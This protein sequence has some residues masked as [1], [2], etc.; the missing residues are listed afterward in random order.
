MTNNIYAL[1]VGIDEYDSN[2]ISLPPLLKGCVNDISAMEQYLKARVTQEGYALHLKTLKNQ[3]A[4]RAAIIHEFQNHLRQAKKSDTVLFYFSGHGSQEQSPEEFVDLGL[5]RLNETLVCYDSRTAE[6]W[7]LADKELAKLIAELSKNQPHISII[8]DCCNSG[9]GTRDTLQETGVRLAGIDKRKR[10]LNSF[11]FQLEELNT[12]SVSGNS[13]AHPSGWKIPRGRHVLLSACQATQKAKEIDRHGQTRGAFSYYLLDTLHQAKGNLTYRDLLGRAKALVSSQVI[14]QSP[15]LELNSSNDENQLFL[16]GAIAEREPYFIVSHNEKYGWVIEGGAVHGIQLPSGEET[17]SLA[18]FPFDSHTEDLRHSSKS[19]GKA[20]VTKVLPSLSKI[21]ISGIEN[22]D[23]NQTFKAVITGLP[24]PPLG[25]YLEGDEEGVSLAR[26]AIQQMPPDNNPSVYVREEE[27]KDSK[28]I[29]YRLLCRDNQYVIARLQD[30]RPLVA[31][32]DGYTPENAQIAIKR[33][34]HIARWE[35]IAE[36]GS[37]GNGLIQESDIEMKLICEDNNLSESEQMRLEYQPREDGATRLSTI[38]IKLTNKSKRTLYCSLLILSDLFA[39]EVP[40]MEA[41]YV[42]LPPEGEPYLSR[43]GR[44]TLPDELG[45]QVTEYNHT[46]KLIVSTDEFDARLLTQKTLGASRKSDKEKGAERG[47]LNPSTLNRLM[48]K[49]QTREWEDAEPEKYED[50]LTKQV[51]ITTVRPLDKTPVSKTE[52]KDLGSGVKLQPHLSL[53]ANTRLSSVSQASRNLGDFI[54]PLILREDSQIT[55][56][57]QFTNSRGTDPGLSVLELTDVENPESVTKKNPLKLLVNISLEESENLLPIAY[58]GELYLPLGLGNRTEEGRTEINLERLPN[59]YTTDRSV[60]GSIWICFVKVVREKLG[61][62]SEDYYLKAVKVAENQTVT[63]VEDI[64]A[65][66]KKA[67]NILLYVHGILGDTKD[68]VKSIQRAKVTVDG[69]KLALNECYDLIL[70]FDY[71]NINTSIS[72]IARILKEELAKVGL[73]ANHGKSLQIVA[74][75]MGGLVSRWFIEREEGNQVVQ[76][77]VMLGTPNAGSPWPTVQDLATLALGIGLNSLSSVAWPVKILGCLVSA[78]EAVDVTLDQMK[79]NSDFLK[80]LAASPDPGIPY[81]VIAGNT[82]IIRAATEQKGEQTS[83][84]KRLIQKLGTQFLEFP[85][86]GQP[87]DIAVTVDSIT[88]ISKARKFPLNIQIVACDHLTYFIDNSVGLEA[89]SAALYLQEDNTKHKKKLLK[90]SNIV[91]LREEAK[92]NEVT[93]KLEQKENNNPSFPASSVSLS[94][95]KP[96]NKHLEKSVESSTEENKHKSQYD[97]EDSFAII[98]GIDK[99]KEQPLKNAASDA[100]KLAAILQEHYKYKVLLLLDEDATLPKLKRLF[101][102]FEKGIIPLNKDSLEEESKNDDK[103]FSKIND[104]H[105][106]LVY[107]AGHGVAKDTLDGV[108]EPQGYLIPQDATTSQA[109]NSY[110]SLSME[111]FHDALIKLACRHM[112]VILDCCFAASFSWAIFREWQPEV[113]LNRQSY[114]RFISDPA[115]QVITSSSQKQKALDSAFGDRGSEDGHSPFALA[116]FKV[117]EIAKQNDAKDENNTNIFDDGILTAHKLCEYLRNKVEVDSMERGQRQTPQIWPLKNHRAGEYIFLLPGFQREVLKL[118]PA[119]KPENNPYRGLESYEEEHSHLFFGRQQLTEKL[120][121]KV[122]N[123]PLTIVTGYSGIGKSSLVKA[124]LIPIYIKQF[125]EQLKIKILNEKPTEII[126]NL[127]KYH[128]KFDQLKIKVEEFSKAQKEVDKLQQEI[129]NIE[130]EV[131]NIEQEAHDVEQEKLEQEL[132]DL[133]KK[134][135]NKLAEFQK[136]LD[137]DLETVKKLGYIKLRITS[138]TLD[139]LNEELKKICI[140]AT[141]VQNNEIQENEPTLISRLLSTFLNWFGGKSEIS[142][143]NVNAEDSLNQNINNWKNLNSKIFGGKRILII[144]QFEEIINLTEEKRNNFLARLEKLVNEHKE[145]LRIVLTMSS[146]MKYV[147]QN[148]FIYEHWADYQFLVEEMKPEQLREAIEKPAQIQTMFF[149]YQPD[150]QDLVNQLLDD[151]GQTPRLLPLVSYTLKELYEKR[152][153]QFKK[154]KRNIYNPDERKFTLKDYQHLGGVKKS[155][156]NQ[157]NSVYEELIEYKELNSRYQDL[158]KELFLIFLICRQN[159][160]LY[161]VSLLQIYFF[162]LVVNSDSYSLMKYVFLELGCFKESEERIGIREEI[163]DLGEKEKIVP[164]QIYMYVIKTVYLPKLEEKINNLQIAWENS[165]TWDK[166][167]KNIMLRMVEVRPPSEITRRRVD[168]SK[169]NYSDNTEN[170]RVEKILKEFEKLNL[171]IKRS[172]QDEVTSTYVELANDIV[173]KEWEEL[174]ICIASEDEKLKNLRREIES[175]ADSWN[176]YKKSEDFLWH[177]NAFYLEQLKEIYKSE[178]NW[179]NELEKDFV[180]ASF[181]KQKELEDEKVELRNEIKKL[182]DEIINKDLNY[183]IPIETLQQEIKRLNKELEESNLFNKSEVIK[184]QEKFEKLE[185]ELEISSIS[186]TNK[187]T[188]YQ[189]EVKELEESNLSGINEVIK[190]Q[191]KIE[192]VEES[193]LPDAKEKLKEL[194]SK[195]KESNVSDTNEVTKYQDKLKELENELKKLEADKNRKKLNNLKNRYIIRSGIISSAITMTTFWGCSRISPNF[196]ETF[197]HILFL[198]PNKRQNITQNP[199]IP[200][201]NRANISE[202]KQIITS[203][204]PLAWVKL[205]GVQ[206]FKDGSFDKAVTNLEKYLN[207]RPNDPEALIY[208]NNAQ[209]SKLNKKFYTIAVSAPIGSDINGALEILR[210]VAQ[211][212]YEINHQK[213]G[214]NGVWLKVLIANDND[215][216]DTAKKI[217]EELVK[218]PDVLGVVGHFSSDVTLEAGKIYNA[219]RLVAISPIS[220]STKLTGFGNYIFRTAPNDSEVAKSLVGYMRS[221]LGKKNAAVFYN[222]KSASSESLKSE[223]ENFLRKERGQVSSVFDL[224]DPNFKADNSIEQSIKSG[225][226][227]LV[228]LP[229]TGKL[230][231]ALQIVKANNKRLPLLGGNDVYTP[232]V[233]KEGANEAVSMVVAVPWH[234]LAS[235]TD[236][237]KTSYDLWGA[238]VNWRTA[239][240]YNATVALIEGLKNTSTP[241]TREGLAQILRSSD[242][243]AMGATGEIKFDAKGDRNQGIQLVEIKPNTKS[244]SKSGY[245]FEPI[246]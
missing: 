225:A 182:Q 212:Q 72:E 147:F 9:S 223:F 48:N 153:E 67:T 246:P 159:L 227:V 224:S 220:T 116:L 179:L 213:G 4:T 174:Q 115:W 124:G 69:E 53:K 192:E 99:Y 51:T 171:L 148:T 38:Q 177:N 215:D 200:E 60:Q 111:E 155:L 134:L 37:S 230:D 193:N 41:G 15:Q 22:L 49:I 214:I 82:S 13:K 208:L 76:H 57:V 216:K 20:K 149:E 243:T 106:V 73:T 123:N 52:S 175:A 168:I 26:N 157:I 219:G 144:D 7:D 194:E 28:D 178:N 217:A 127:E 141:Q 154:N 143:P 65:Q 55:Q 114:D 104:K 83:R 137:K 70:T 10:P 91:L 62:K 87:N 204:D 24:L 90:Q 150:G 140:F 101:G 205:A 195:L 2:S 122:D 77:L 42:K 172:S 236:F 36:L 74:H 183:K 188:K 125:Q 56:A 29:R 35:V 245:D 119:L 138:D 34:E 126:K 40:S 25:V 12:L 190:Y 27:N 63:P 50:W 139:T 158:I 79:P 207:K 232:K 19:I 14:E 239:M 120:H 5:N 128:L 151:V 121:E 170:K 244:R 108:D 226:E 68:I 95:E 189:E 176:N 58:D 103:K 113:T 167:I 54:L 133:N 46:I 185:N 162:Y 94:E 163:L 102:F 136:Q 112:L 203:T 81:S 109:A 241:P 118:A 199:P 238:S 84:L 191:E 21:E 210:G 66:V 80:D 110:N 184:Y 135:K 23:T 142:N 130:Q 186:N 209:I 43:S 39:V 93:Q 117:L 78:I 173:V 152:V 233:L 1:L 221:K 211:A 181:K 33:L 132:N 161:L 202:G 30:D 131:N 31:Q 164:L 197:N 32:I 71:E 45:K 201:I 196:N 61:Q 47:I 88:S 145:W 75:S 234:I 166:T 165:I 235:K 85:F 129:N 187:V 17:T 3:E 218:I 206:A 44:L 96:V 64:P 8:L 242:F 59:P 18:L 222:S 92:S 198:P 229:N 240:S 156:V 89:L 237:P 180:E 231:D 100:K 160:V 86:L 11:I 146:D 107:F 16:N 6:S 105:R 169:L 97:F 228:L 98:I